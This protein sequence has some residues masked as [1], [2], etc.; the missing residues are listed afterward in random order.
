MIQ[1]LDSVLA[2]GSSKNESDQSKYG[3]NYVE[4]L[5]SNNFHWTEVTNYPYHDV[6]YQ[7]GIIS[8]RGYF[9]VFGGH[10][11]GSG[12]TNIIARLDRYFDWHHM[13]ILLKKHSGKSV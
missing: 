8:H 13:G 10:T 9:Y 4:V 2:I 12:K 3:H 11:N 6:I 7:A 5:N 1:T